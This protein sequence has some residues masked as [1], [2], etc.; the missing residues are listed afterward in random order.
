MQN[1]VTISLDRISKRFGENIAV[2]D[3]TFTMVQGECLALVGHNGAGKSTL[4]KMLL[5]LVKPSE[6][7]IEL[8]GADSQSSNFVEIRKQIGFLPEQILFQNNMT[9]FETLSFYSKLKNARQSDI[10]ALFE[11]VD[12]LAAAHQRIATY[13]KGMR[14]RLGLAQALIGQPKFLILD[15]PT[16]G[17]DPLSR[18]RVYAIINEVKNAGAT[19]LI[20]SHALTELDERIDR[21]AIMNK[22]ALAAIGDVDQLRSSIGL[23]SMIK[24]T[25][26]HEEMAKIIHHFRHDM[27]KFE[28]KQ[29]RLS[30]RCP[31]EEKPLLLKKIFELNVNIL[32]IEIVDPSL[33]QV[34]MRY[35]NDVNTVGVEE[36]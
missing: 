15:E 11:R 17:L 10:L 34:F 19:V 36:L 28:G 21:V 16:T 30:L 8:M 31:I 2:N 35:T 7:D 14:Q 26:N 29:D 6:G 3:V 12:L 25:A 18:Q 23:T 33:E 32:N 20:S 5:G 9:G 13:S 4:I 1:E 22:G 24:L 27:V